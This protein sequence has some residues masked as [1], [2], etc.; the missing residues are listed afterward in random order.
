[1]HLQWFLYY[2]G[3]KYVDFRNII[4]L[5]IHLLFLA[6]GLLQE[7]AREK[8][9]VNVYI[10]QQPIALCKTGRFQNSLRQ[11]KE[12]VLRTISQLVWFK[13]SLLVLRY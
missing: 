4:L 1:M 3:C 9:L 7:K 8:G 5:Q 13:K 6:A 12:K 10:F 11:M 2:D